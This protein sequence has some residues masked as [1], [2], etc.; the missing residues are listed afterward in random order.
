MALDPTVVA[1]MESEPAE[2]V[3]VVVL[4]ACLIE[5]LHPEAEQKDIIR[6][7]VRPERLQLHPVQ[8]DRQI[9]HLHDLLMGILDL[10]V[11]MMRRLEPIHHQVHHLHQAVAAVVQEVKVEAH[12]RL[13]AVAVDQLEEAVDNLINGNTQHR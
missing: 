13:V 7:Q 9:A 5:F 4:M 10:H 3:T 2:T 6:T 12:H 1:K 11:Q 8:M